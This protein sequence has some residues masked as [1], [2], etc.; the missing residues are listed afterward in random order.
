MKVFM[1]NF[2]FILAFLST[3]LFEAQRNCVSD[4]LTHIEAE[5]PKESVEWYFVSVDNLHTQA[6]LLF[7]KELNE[8]VFFQVFAQKEDNI[9]YEYAF[10]LEALDHPLTPEVKKIEFVIGNKQLSDLVINIHYLE[11]GY[12]ECSDKKSYSY[13]VK[14][15]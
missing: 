11:R 8:A 10:P 9:L 14:A 15:S 1:K 3:N 5:M 13:Y 4:G 7:P 6:S 2:L 12:S